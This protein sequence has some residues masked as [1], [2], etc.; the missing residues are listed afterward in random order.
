MARR[1]LLR[2][3]AGAA[4]GFVALL[5]Q[6]AIDNNAAY[7]G[8]PG[9]REVSALHPGYL[10][11]W[12]NVADSPA[13]LRES[14]MLDVLPEVDVLSYAGRLYVADTTTALR[15]LN[16]REQRAQRLEN[17]LAEIAGAGRNPAFDLKISDEKQL[18]DL[19]AAVDALV[20]RDALVVVS[21]TYASVANLKLAG[22]RNLILVPTVGPANENSYYRDA[23]QW[24]SNSGGVLRG[25]TL[26]ESFARLSGI[27]EFNLER[28]LQT[29]VYGVRSEPDAAYF[30]SRGATLI[31]TNRAALLSRARGTA[32]A[33]S[34]R[35]GS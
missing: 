34:R 24:R 7:A 13:M 35:R 9:F 17:V 25:A 18:K 30:I 33:V 21:G 29:N 11:V 32:Q 4:I 12:H 1:T 2:W 31:T 8:Q 26:K 23:E 6:Q 27:L 22:R 19:E 10:L 28:G 16:P 3:S 15:H 20:P 14:L 5:M